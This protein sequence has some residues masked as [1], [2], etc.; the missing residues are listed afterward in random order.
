MTET[1]KH[2]PSFK[3]KLGNTTYTV[4]VH[5]DENSKETFEDRVK[6]LI[7]NDCIENQRKA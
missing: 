1:E 7:V 3:K 6:R 5:F 2:I 4:K